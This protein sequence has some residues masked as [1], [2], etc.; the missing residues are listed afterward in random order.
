MTELAVIL[1]PAGAA[2]LY[3]GLKKRINKAY[4]LHNTLTLWLFAAVSASVWFFQTVEMFQQNPDTGQRIFAVGVLIAA[5]AIGLRRTRDERRRRKL[6]IHNMDKGDLKKLLESLLEKYRI[7]YQRTTGDAGMTEYSFPESDGK[8][9]VKPHFAGSQHQVL[10]V[11]KIDE[12]PDGV[13]LVE[14]L[15]T[16]VADVER[17]MSKTLGLYEIV[18]GTGLLAAVT[19]F[20]F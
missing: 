3:T 17:P 18:M 9:T 12:V 13:E 4:F 16:E 19:Y 10:T 2:L 20:I 8:I 5:A 14:D 15:K 11:E 7:A 1:A 6:S